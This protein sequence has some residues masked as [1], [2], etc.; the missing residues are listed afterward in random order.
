MKQLPVPGHFGLLYTAPAALTESLQSA[1]AHELLH[2]CLPLYAST[3]R[4]R[5]TDSPVILRTEMGKPYFQDFPDVHFNLS[6]CKGL[7]ACLLSPYECGVDTER[8]RPVRE[9]VA[10]RVFSPEEQ[11][12]LQTAPD[13][14]LFFTQ[15][16][17]LKE[18]Y[19]KAVGVGISYP[20]REVSFTFTPDGIRCSKPDAAF[21]Q[22]IEGE[23][24]I[25]VCI[26]KA[27]SP[28]TA[29]PA[30]HSAQTALPARN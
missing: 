18:S 28:G 13:P 3:R 24:V 9:R 4:I 22:C 19:V 10:A 7:A 26:L 30:D 27:P 20:M 23:F 21:W 16:W 14:D 11:A 15:L 12:A 2:Q 8:K 1:A 6:H 5:L 29:P 17:T 25:S